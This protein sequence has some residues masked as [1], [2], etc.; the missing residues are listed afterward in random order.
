MKEISAKELKELID[1]KADI[2]IA[3]VREQHEFDAAN[4]NGD[5][6]P[7]GTIPTNVS[8]ISKDKQVIVICRSGRR[9]ENAIR[10]LE[11][12]HGFTKL[13]NLKGGILAWKAEVDNSL[14]VS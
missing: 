3:D 6:I 2:Q 7:L 8:R 9:S 5:L 1:Q 12:N 13:F 4:I 14:K 11:G 10:F